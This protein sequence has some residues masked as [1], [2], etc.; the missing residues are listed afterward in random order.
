[1]EKTNL[2]TKA[3][4]L[5][6]EG[7]VEEALD[8]LIENLNQQHHNYQDI[9]NNLVFLK[10]NYLSNIEQ[11]EIK[12]TISKSDFDL[13]KA[14]NIDGI[15]NVI[16]KIETPKPLF[17]PKK[18]KT[19]FNILGGLGF[20]LLLG[21]SYYFFFYNE[22]VSKKE[23]ASIVEGEHQFIG[24]WLAKVEKKGY[25]DDQ[26]IRTIYEDAEAH[27]N[28]TIN[29]DHTALLSGTVDTTGKAQ[30]TWFFNGTK[31]T[32]TLIQEDKTA[33]EIVI[34]ENHK[35]EQIWQTSTK[36]GNKTEEWKWKLTRK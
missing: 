12:M 5:I 2:R 9:T 20:V 25:L 32:L 18:N 31:E 23:P 21:S 30:F 36:R 6:G 35:E 28:I 29:P 16:K 7:K 3:N 10:S 1:M 15:L 26:G 27:W 11:Y 8:Y 33:F 17:F 22:E 24:D 34:K 13:A 4:Q 14:K 19:L